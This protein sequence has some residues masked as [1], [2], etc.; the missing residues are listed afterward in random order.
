MAINGIVHA[1]TESKWGISEESTFGTPIADTGAF[2]KMEGPIPTVDPGLFRDNTIKFGSGRVRSASEDF[3]SPE[4]GT[5]VLSFS[6]LVVRQKDLG[7]LLYLVCQNVSEGAGT[8]YEKTFTFTNATTQPDFSANGGSFV[9][10]GINDTIASYHRKYT[11]CILRTLT[12]SSDLSGDGLVRASGEF[13]SGHAQSTTANFNT[14]AWDYNTQ[15]YY[16][17][18]TTPTKKIGGSDI[19][20]YGW[21]LTINNNGVRVGDTGAG[22]C[23]TYAIGVG[24][25]GYD[26][27]GNIKAK[28]DANTQGLIAAD[29]AGTTTAIQ[30]AC[31]VDGATGNFDMTMS[32]SIIQNVG[33]DYENEKG[34]ALDLYV[35]DDYENEKGRALDLSFIC[36]VP[37]LTFTCSDANDRA[38]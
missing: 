33:D 29:I 2:E 17:F 19:V 13:I 34:R 10:I 16:N 15:A 7:L 4:G 3:I 38:W 18:H 31:G 12:L 32:N 6:D 36:H 8:P 22:L 25:T 30:L 23:E 9:T 14:G 28:F 37:T 21:D 11:S 5:R 24:S 20:L 27:S 1:G 26:I 35:G